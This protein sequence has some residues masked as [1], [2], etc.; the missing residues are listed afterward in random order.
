MADQKRKIFISDLH[1]DENHP[2]ITREFIQLLEK[3]HPLNEEI[4]I[5]GDLF[6]AWVGDDNLTT[7]NQFIMRSLKEA[8]QRGMKIYFIHGNRDFL[9]NGKF[10]AETGC[11]L[12]SDPEKIIIFDQP[13]LLMHGDT[14]CTLDVKY[15]RARRWFRNR[16][17]QRLFL[18]LPL[19]L[20]RNI[21]NR[22]RMKSQKYTSTMTSDIMDVSQDEVEHVMN[23]YNV[24]TL[25]HGHTHKPMMHTFTLNNLSAERIV[26]SA[27]HD[28]GN[29]LVWDKDGKQ[30]C[31]IPEINP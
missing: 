16:F 9:I 31:R 20:R 28:K 25:I 6:E 5:L 10:F 22:M 24:Q 11:Q 21:A 26:L 17:I 14:L 3:S 12:L 30:F 8:T 1:L 13:V 7:F 23:K 18:S 29:A 4:Y 2:E 27:W 15:L 19:P